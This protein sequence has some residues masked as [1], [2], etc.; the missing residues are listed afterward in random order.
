MN[1]TLLMK[2]N[3]KDL[4]I[5]L[6]IF[7]SV[8]LLCLGQFQFIDSSF[9][10]LYLNVGG[11][12]LIACLGLSELR[13]RL[14]EK[15]INQLREAATT[16]ALT[17]VGNRRAFDIEL[18]RRIALFRRH[19]GNCSLLIIDADHF[20]AIN[21]RWGHDVGDL[22]LKSLAKAISATL[23][24]IDLLY[25]FGGEEFVALLPETRAEEAGIAGERIRKAV[26]QVKIR[27]ADKNLSFSVSIGCAELNA[28]DNQDSLIKRADEALYSAKKNGRNRVEIGLVSNNA[29]EPSDAI[30]KSDAGLKL[31]PQEPTIEGCSKQPGLQK[32]L[33]GIP[34]QSS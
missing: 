17:L 2:P 24:D 12:G 15:E 19:R 25:R 16:D 34:K 21:D 22:A 1:A 32:M 20:K 7:G 29:C 26:N 18:T 5:W 28:S 31:Q 23:R 6:T 4:P 27:I 30:L 13:R 10:M 11:I 8:T 14:G 9:A 3:L 33:G